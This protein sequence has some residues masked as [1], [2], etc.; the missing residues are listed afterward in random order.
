MGAIIYMHNT[1]IW[2]FGR[3]DSPGAPT[4]RGGED[5]SGLAVVPPTGTAARTA[6]IV[7]ESAATGRT[8][9]A[10]TA[11]GT[12]RARLVNHE[13]PVT[14]HTAVE[15]LD[16]AAGLLRRRHLHEAE[17]PGTTGELVRHDAHRLDGPGLLEELPKV[18][19]RGLVGQV[20]YEELRGH[21]SPPAL[22]RDKKAPGEACLFEGR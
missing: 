11:P 18:V 9:A 4:R 10:A 12:L 6:A 7:A 21:R 14:E 19:L 2:T 8:T 15:L 22:R 16:R 20:A 13:I 17:A 1:R 3:T 5:G